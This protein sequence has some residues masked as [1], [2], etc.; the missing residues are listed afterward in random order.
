MKFDYNKAIQQAN[1]IE[2]AARTL[3]KAAC[4]KFDSAINALSTAWQG[5]NAYLFTNK[6][7]EMQRDMK[8][9]AEKL[10]TLADK[11]RRVAATIRETEEHA[12]EIQR[13]NA[14]GGGRAF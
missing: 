3:K 1:T 4:S 2:Y 9:Q 10:S 7:L 6:C 13:Q 8:T 12:K 11:L 5:E 14:I